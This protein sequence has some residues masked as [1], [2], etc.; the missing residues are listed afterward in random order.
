[1]Y[2]KPLAILFLMVLQKVLQKNERKND[3]SYIDPNI[4]KELKARIKKDSR[5]VIRKRKGVFDATF[6]TNFYGGPSR[7]Q[8]IIYRQDHIPSNM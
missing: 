6:Q 1:M 8:H 2:W 3:P 4:I 7:S 5:D